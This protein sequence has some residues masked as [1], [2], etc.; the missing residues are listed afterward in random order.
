M[1]FLEVSSG[2]IV[3]SISHPS[4]YTHT[5]NLSSFGIW[6]VSDYFKQ[7]Y[8]EV[9]SAISSVF[10]HSHHSVRKLQTP[11]EKVHMEGIYRRT[12]TAALFVII[13]S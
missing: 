12:V 6:V 10:G 3:P 2:V 5:R 1:E 9:V 4:L 7:W 11:H 13:H 8:A